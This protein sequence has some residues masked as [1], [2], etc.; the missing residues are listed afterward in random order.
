MKKLTPV[1]T[2]L[3]LLLSGSVTAQSLSLAT[4]NIGEHPPVITTDD[5]KM[6]D[7]ADLN[8]KTDIKRHV[9]ALT[10]LSDEYE[11]KVELRIKTTK[12]LDCNARNLMVNTTKKTVNGWGYNYYVA[13]VSGI[14]STMMMCHESPKV[15]EIYAAPQELLRYNSKLPLVIYTPSDVQLEVRVWTPSETYQ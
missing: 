13:E 15:K 3:T 12:K 2:V 11:A 14:Q 5:L 6:Y 1:A 8:N 10:P 9:I 7:V 4:I